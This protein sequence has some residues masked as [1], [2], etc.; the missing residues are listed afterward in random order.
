MYLFVRLPACGW[1]ECRHHALSVT[2]AVSVTGLPRE[3]RFFCNPARVV[4]Q[5]VLLTCK[6]CEVARISK[7][8]HF[9]QPSVVPVA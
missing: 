1:R 4:L 2:A 7:L 9:I 3:L 5:A 8:E 6:L